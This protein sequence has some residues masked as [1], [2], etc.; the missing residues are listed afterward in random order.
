MIS[1]CEKQPEILVGIRFAAVVCVTGVT[2]P[3]AVHRLLA[4]RGTTP[5]VVLLFYRNENH[6]V[7]LDNRHYNYK[8]SVKGELR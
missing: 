2:R 4:H 5:A 3:S 8:Q 7:Q 1:L 6:L